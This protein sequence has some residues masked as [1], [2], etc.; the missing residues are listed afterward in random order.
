MFCAQR[1]LIFSLAFLCLSAAAR[2]D[3]VTLTPVADTMLSEYFPVN[4]FGATDYLN[5][6]TSERNTRNRALLRFDFGTIPPGSRITSATLKIEVTRVSNNGYAIAQFNVH[7]LLVPWGEGIQTNAPGG[8]QGQGSPAQTNEATWGHRFAF[9]TNTWSSPGGG[10]TNDYFHTASTANTIYTPQDYPFPSTS[11][12]VADVQLWLD[13]PA[14]N[15]GWIIV[16]ANEAAL[17]TARRFGSREDPVNTPLLT[18]DYLPFQIKNPAAT[19]NQFRFNFTQFAGRP[20]EVQHRAA[21][22]TGSW[23]T[24]AQFPAP[25][26]DTNVVVTDSISQTQRF[27]RLM[28]P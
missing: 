7:R 12:L 21:V 24:L 13:Q 14:T 10:A 18:I 9:T 19:N 25:A 15:F 6:G 20:V 23:Q 28:T 2:A 27:Y 11:G 3:S 17:Y 16:C 22:N 4:N 1:P 5:C 26:A 8:L